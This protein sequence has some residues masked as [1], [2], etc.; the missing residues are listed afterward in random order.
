MS[1]CQKFLFLGALYLALFFELE[2][3]VTIP[4]SESDATTRMNQGGD[5][6][7]RGG[8]I[9]EQRSP[10]YIDDWWGRNDYYYSRHG[11]RETNSVTNPYYNSYYPR[12]NTEYPP[13]SSSYNNSGRY[14][15]PGYPR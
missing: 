13:D 5:P 8:L 12:P 3:Y 4:R 9:D 15:R 10:E 7:Q 1:H 6:P 14:Y 2:A 11:I